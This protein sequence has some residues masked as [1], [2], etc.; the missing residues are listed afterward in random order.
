MTS[1]VSDHVLEVA[2]ALRPTVLRLARELRRETEQFGVTSRQSA[3]LAHVKATPGAS[4]S[5]LAAEEGIS[6]AA[7]SSHVDRLV[8]RGL[9][10]R[11]RF[12]DDRRRVGLRLTDD[13]ARVLRRVRERRTAWLA[14][15]LARLDR[16]GLQRVERA[17]PALL[18][19]P[20]ERSA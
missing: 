13:G 15:R 16:D 18:E 9:V 8:R 7:L 2:G 4:L 11:E 19:L 17:L 6:T 20:V 14:C 12:E 1:Q 3:L 5:E 10:E